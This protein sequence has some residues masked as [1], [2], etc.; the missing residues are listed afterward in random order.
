MSLNIMISSLLSLLVFLTSGF[1]EAL[2]PISVKGTKLFDD[3]GNQFFIRGTV[4]N[5]LKLRPICKAL[6]N[7]V[8]V[9]PTPLATMTQTLSWTPNDAKPTRP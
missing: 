5:P 8:Q 2:S 9:S 3:D 1:V 6:T 7:S 4:T